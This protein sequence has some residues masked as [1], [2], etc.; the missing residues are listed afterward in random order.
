MNLNSTITIKNDTLL[1]KINDADL[2]I[3]SITDS[4]IGNVS[5]T[6]ANALISI[7]NTILVGVINIITYD[8][9]VSLNGL[10]TKIGIEFVKFGP[11]TLTPF[12]EY[13]L[14]YTT[15]IFDVE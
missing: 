1:L 11:T 14:F 2:K 10:L 8:I 7:F 3:A 5:P 15:L 6:I 4:T 12:D 13:F 9:G